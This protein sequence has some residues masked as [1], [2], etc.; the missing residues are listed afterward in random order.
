[1]GGVQKGQE[2]A[3]VNRDG[4][5]QTAIPI[6]TVRKKILGHIFFDPPLRASLFNKVTIYKSPGELFLFQSIKSLLTKQIDTLLVVLYPM[7]FNQIYF[8]PHF[9]KTIC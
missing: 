2:Y 3:E 4:P 1:M 7:I 8:Q 9:L 6:A 5:Q